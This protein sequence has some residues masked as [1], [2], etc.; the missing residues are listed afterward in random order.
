MYIL[1]HKI[2]K[3]IPRPALSPHSASSDGQNLMP[4]QS[5]GRHTV[6]TSCGAPDAVRAQFCRLRQSQEHREARAEQHAELFIEDAAT[7]APHH[8][9]TSPLHLLLSLRN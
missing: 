9:T 8:N 2:L 1:A 4:T 7:H 6:V 5:M 3:G